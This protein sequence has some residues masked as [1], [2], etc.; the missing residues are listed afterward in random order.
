MSPDR[1]PIGHIWD[2]LD[3]HVRA[4][5]NQP[6]SLAQLQAALLQ[7]WNNLPSKLFIGALGP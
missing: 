4:R 7:E 3:R 2:E 5:L 1:S 6:A